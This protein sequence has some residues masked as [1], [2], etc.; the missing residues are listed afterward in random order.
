MNAILS[1]SQKSAIEQDVITIDPDTKDMLKSINFENLA[2][3]E[4]G[5]SRA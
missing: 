1:L 4:V 2:G 5:N 3:V